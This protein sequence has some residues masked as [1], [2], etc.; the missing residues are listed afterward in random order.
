ME[1]N[2]EPTNHACTVNQYLTKESRILSGERQSL[3]YTVLGK[4]DIHM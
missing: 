3:R 2:G 1:R 4:L